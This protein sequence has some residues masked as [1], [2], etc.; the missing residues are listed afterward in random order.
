MR[1][2]TPTF[3]ITKRCH[4]VVEWG[5]AVVFRGAGGRSGIDDFDDA[6]DGEL[7]FEIRGAVPEPSTYG[8]IGA[9]VLSGLAL[10]RRRSANHPARV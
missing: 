7:A 3:P 5:E 9:A 8:A 10:W 1:Y 4:E 6:I 2:T